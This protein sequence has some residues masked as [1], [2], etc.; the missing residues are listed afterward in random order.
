MRDG[1]RAETVSCLDVSELPGSLLQ[2]Y[3]VIKNNPTQ[4]WVLFLLLRRRPVL[5]WVHSRRWP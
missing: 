1:Q 2:V 3:R 4:F 5:L